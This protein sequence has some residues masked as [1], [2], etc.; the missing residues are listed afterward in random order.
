MWV[1]KLAS[2]VFFG[3]LFYVHQVCSPPEALDW[4]PSAFREGECGPLGWRRTADPRRC[5]VPSHSS[6]YERAGLV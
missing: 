1:M 3:L 5:K 2:L 6:F 4:P